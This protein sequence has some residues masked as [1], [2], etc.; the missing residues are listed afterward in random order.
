[1]YLPLSGVASRFGVWRLIGVR[2]L[3][4][5]RDRSEVLGT[6][7]CL[8]PVLTYPILFHLVCEERLLSGSFSELPGLEPP[9][10][11]LG[12][13]VVGGFYTRATSPTSL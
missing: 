8:R 12:S 4:G 3:S 1:M 6:G 2:A 13:A 9:P 7:D 10:C 11:W 5:V